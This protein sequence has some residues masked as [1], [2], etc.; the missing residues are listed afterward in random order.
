MAARRISQKQKRYVLFAIGLAAGAALF[1]IASS[2]RAMF[3]FG[4][5]K[6]SVATLEFKVSDKEIT[7]FVSD[8]RT[9]SNAHGLSFRSSTVTPDGREYSILMWRKDIAVA[10]I[11]SIADEEFKLIFY[12]DEKNSG[13]VENARALASELDRELKNRAKSQ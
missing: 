3:N 11:N 2:E 12:I 9:L 4:E 6:S 5:S 13:T 1:S 7:A 8:L 10:A